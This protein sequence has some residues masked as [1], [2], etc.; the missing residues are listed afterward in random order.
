MPQSTIIRIL[1][2]ELYWHPPGSDGSLQSLATDEARA[3]LGSV[4]EG[5]RKGCCLA[6]PGEAVRLLELNIEEDE[7]RHIQFE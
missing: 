5:Q 1:D 3:A 4:L 7:R 6:L 2:G